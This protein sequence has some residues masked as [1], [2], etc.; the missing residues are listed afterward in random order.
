MS[1]TIIDTIHI[2]TDV[3]MLL[4]RFYSYHGAAVSAIT[5]HY[6]HDDD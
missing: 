1:I 3:T 6:D 2:I 4:V 5:N